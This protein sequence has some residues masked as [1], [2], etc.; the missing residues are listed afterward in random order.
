MRKVTRYCL[1]LVATV[2]M[3]VGTSQAQSSAL[4]VEWRQF[5]NYGNSPTFSPDG[6]MFATA[7]NEMVYVYALPHWV[8]Q[9]SFRV[10]SVRV[11]RFSPDGRFLATLGTDG[12]ARLW[13]V[14]NWTLQQTFSVAPEPG[15]RLQF[16]RLGRRLAVMGY[17]VRVWDV[18][19]RTL[20]YENTAISGFQFDLS[21]NGRYIATAAN[22]PEPAVAVFDIEADTIVARFTQS[23]GLQLQAIAFSPDGNTLAFTNR[24]QTFLVDTGTWRIRAQFVDWTQVSGYRALAFSPDNQILYAV[25]GYGSENTQTVYP[26]RIRHASN[27]GLIRSAYLSPR[28]RDSLAVSPDGEW[29]ALGSVVLEAY[30]TP[31]HTL[32]TFSEFMDPAYDIAIAPSGLWYATADS[33]RWASRRDIRTG[34][35]AYRT[36]EGGHIQTALAV[37][38]SPDETRLATGGQD[39]RICL[40]DAATGALERI[41]TGSLGPVL[42]VAFLGDGSTLLSVGADGFIRLW[43]AETGVQLRSVALGMQIYAARLSAN[44]EWLVIGGQ[45]RRVRLFRV[46][47]LTQVAQLAQLP[48]IPNSVAISPRGERVAIGLTNGALLLVDAPSMTVRSER[49]YNASPLRL[50]FAPDGRHL[51]LGGNRLDRLVFLDTHTNTVVFETEYEIASGVSVLTFTPT[52]RSLIFA[53]SDTAHLRVRN[54][55][56]RSGDVNQ[57]GCVDDADLLELLLA[58]GNTGVELAAD[59]NDD[60]IVDDADLLTVLFHF[61]SGC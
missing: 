15:I 4:E 61:G 30:H 20:L 43:S 28:V 55:V 42:C 8:P 18:D 32:H 53:R 2:G 13:D 10:P 44:K 12:I 56:Y 34:I 29:V 48:E 21:P 22:V 41:I 14:S 60:G 24:N 33:L 54:P 9:Y 58:F 39:S 51:V 11:C 35:R 46:S 7:W 1:V 45:D 19:T 25:G 49:R 59:I 5:P 50:A 27:G 52:G 16:D 38:I 31:T 36:P 57:D 37:A 26:L 47:D 23:E 40:W 17:G 3:A 6:T